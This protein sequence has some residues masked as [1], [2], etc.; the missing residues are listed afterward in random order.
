M[1]GDQQQSGWTLVGTSPATPPPPSSSSA[2]EPQADHGW[3]SNASNF[4]LG[5]LSQFNPV[6]IGKGIYGMITHP[7][8]TA[9]GLGTAQVEQF[10][11]GKAEYDQGH[12]P[13]AIGHALAGALPIVG[14][15]AAD[16]GEALGTGQDTAKNLGKAVGLT[17]LV[18]PSAITKPI[19]VVANKV[20]GGVLRATGAAEPMAAAAERGAQARVTDV[21]GPKGSSATVKRMG[22]TAASHAQDILDEPGMSAISRRGLHEQVKTKLAD[23]SDQ[24]DEA[25]EAS[26][27]GKAY[28]TQPL[29]QALLD[30]RRQFVA[31][32]I[33]GSQVTPNHVGSGLIKR[34]EAVPLGEDVVTKP[35][36]VAVID[37]AL[38]KLDKLGPMARYDALKKLRQEYDSIAAAS[39]KYNPAVTPDYGKVKPVAEGAADVAGAFREFLATQEPGTAKANATYHVWKSLDTVLN[40]AEEADRVRPK[41][42]RQI[43]ARGTGAVVG[44]SAFGLKGAIAGYFGG[45]VLD[46][47]LSSGVTTKILTAKSLDRLAKALRGDDVGAIDIELKKLRATILMANAQRQSQ[48]NGSKSPERP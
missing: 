16:I 7:I 17:A 9:I 8:D 40:A 6:E 33:P 3:L 13:E 15:A 41:V 23:A 1:T 47:L 12:Y 37:E 5:V 44:E 45:P 11:K 27:R 22:N 29:R 14:P 18:S 48:R 4:A 26:N 36:R 24:I 32:A 28:P 30:K 42:G 46:N 39:D 43:V 10:K 21:I 35:D 25:L 38:A 34:P 2:S 19:G 31:E 20:G